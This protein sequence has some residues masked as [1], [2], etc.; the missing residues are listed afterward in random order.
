MQTMIIYLVLAVAALNATGAT[1]IA[2]P[3]LSNGAEADLPVWL[4]W[5][6]KYSESIRNLVLAGGGLIFGAVGLIMGGWR[7]LIA[8]KN[9]KIA[10]EAQI[11]ERFT[12]AIEQL[13]HQSIDV[14]M[15]AIYALERIAKDSP[16]DH[17]TIVETLCAYVRER[18]SLT[19]LSD[20]GK[21]DDGWKSERSEPPTDIEAAMMVLGRRDVSIDPPDGHLNLRRVNLGGIRLNGKEEQH[22]IFNGADFTNA[23]FV[24]AV[25]W[26]VSFAEARFLGADFSK[27]EVSETNFAK[28][29]CRAAKFNDAKFLKIDFSEAQLVRANLNAA[30]FLETDMRGANLS[31]ANLNGTHLNSANL[32]SAK[33][34]QATCVE[35]DFSEAILMEARLAGAS[36]V[37]AKLGE[38]NA[39]QANF[40]GANLSG[41]DLY[42]A[43]IRGARGLD[44]EQL[45]SALSWAQAY[46][47]PALSCEES[48]PT[49]P[50]Q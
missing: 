29:I 14:R 15:G 34:S 48:I 1:S 38:A 11:T 12:K 37:S 47:D 6:F 35:A 44:C 33:L 41:T 4:A 18:A 9:R 2:I 16:Q 13:G 19:D 50:E 49:P 46:R 31:G 30:E 17:W 20:D 27:A 8:D 32:T 3:S 5:L 39:K 21:S 24:K 22:L 25:V 7:L 40:S 43:D 28:A 45:Q 23:R 42:H 10:Q 26:H 36:L